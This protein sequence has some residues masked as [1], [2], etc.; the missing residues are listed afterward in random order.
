MRE[1]ETMATPLT[2]PTLRSIGLA[3]L[4]WLAGAA[5]TALPAGADALQRA[6]EGDIVPPPVITPDVESPYQAGTYD[7]KITNRLNDK[8]GARLAYIGT[9]GVLGQRM[10]AIPD[11]PICPAGA[12]VILKRPLPAGDR[13]YNS[14]C[15]PPGMGFASATSVDI[16]GTPT[17]PG[18]MATTI[19]LCGTCKG[20][21]FGSY[22]Y[23]MRATLH[24]RIG[25]RKTRKLE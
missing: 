16:V 22:G 2:K 25:G 19:L 10:R 18:E 24:W 5:P 14:G 6:C 11:A 17:E 3:A 13:R 15:C 21:S 12:Q 8:P 4:I 9:E 1:D 23:P 20:S 7:R